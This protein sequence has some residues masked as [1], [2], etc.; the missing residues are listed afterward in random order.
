MKTCDTDINIESVSRF[1]PDQ[2]LKE[3]LLSSSFCQ[4]QKV[5]AVS[6]IGL[7]TK[8]PGKQLYGVII[9]LALHRILCLLVD[10]LNLGRNRSIIC[11]IIHPVILLV[12][13]IKPF[14]FSAIF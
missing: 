14:Q 9:M 1:E 13:A 11:K 4:T 12:L 8:S 10:N 5:A 2:M 3:F 6:K 7:Q